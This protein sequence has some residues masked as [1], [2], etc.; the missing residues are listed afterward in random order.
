MTWACRR[1]QLGQPVERLVDRDEVE[2]LFLEVVD[3]EVEGDAPQAPASPFG[4][5]PTCMIDQDL[6][7]GPCGRGEQEAP[8]RRPV[9][10]RLAQET[11]HGLVDHRGG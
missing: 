1:V 7:H 3:D 9:E 2:P 11:D 5:P 8:V 4:V 6:A 10:D